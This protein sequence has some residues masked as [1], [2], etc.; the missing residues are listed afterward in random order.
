MTERQSSRLRILHVAAKMLDQHGEPQLRISGVCKKAKVTAPSIYHFFDSRE[1]L[2]DAA[3]AFLFVQGQAELGEA[4]G[5]ATYACASKSGFAAIVDR[6]ARAAFSDARRHVRSRRASV[7]GR[8][9][10]SESLSKQLNVDQNVSNKLIGDPLRFAQA[11]GWVRSDFDTE[12]FA[13][14]FVGMTTARCF[15]E[16]GDTHPK[17]AQWDT[18]AI[19]A[20]FSGLGLN[21]PA[22]KRN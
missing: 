14:W 13:A 1:G 20:V 17:T 11:K 22:S 10:N 4:F 12:M 21:P 5:E 19:R 7:L 15:I 16:F 8:A 18:I 3:Q 6:F 9:Q 2:I